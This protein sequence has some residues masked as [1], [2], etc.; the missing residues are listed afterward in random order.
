[1]KN[2][3]EYLSYLDSP[4]WKAKRQETFLYYGKECYTCG[5]S[6]KLHVH[7]ITYARFKNEDVATD[8]IPLCEK[9]HN[10]LHKLQKE[11]GISVER[12]S[13]VFFFEFKQYRNPKIRI[14]KVKPVFVHKLKRP[15]K[16]K[17]YINDE[18]QVE[19]WKQALLEREANREK[20]PEEM[21]LIVAERVRLRR[22]EREK[23]SASRIQKRHELGIY[24]KRKKKKK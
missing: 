22:E 16:N 18:S 5:K 6:K 10:K 1:M 4:E 13:R 19:K 15:K 17:V 24:Q 23:K 21:R 8:L 2:Q 11:R 7:H 14:K 12:A 20:T 3:K 9:C